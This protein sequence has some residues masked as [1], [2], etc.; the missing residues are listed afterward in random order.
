MRWCNKPEM[1]GMCQSQT[2]LPGSS[3]VTWQNTGL[4]LVSIA[5]LEYLH[6][7]IPAPLATLSCVT[8]AVERRC[9]GH[10]PGFCVL[11]ILSSVMWLCG[12]CYG[13]S[14]CDTECE[15]NVGPWH[16]CELWITVN[17]T[18]WLLHSGKWLLDFCFQQKFSTTSSQCWNASLDPTNVVIIG[19]WIKIKKPWSHNKIGQ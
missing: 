9:E 7:E 10:A 17:L 6:Q 1:G 3:L 12:Q 4:W 14:P 19:L 5:A 16:W 15:D 13:W 18:P 8:D 2:T 11:L